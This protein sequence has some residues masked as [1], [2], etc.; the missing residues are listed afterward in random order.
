MRHTPEYARAHYW[1]RRNYGMMPIC[2]ADNCKNKSKKF[3]WALKKGKVHGK[4]REN[5]IRLCRSCHMKYDWNEDKQKRL[6]DIGHT[7]EINDKI[8]AYRTGRKF[9]EITKKKM[10]D[11][12]LGVAIPRSWKEVYQFDRDEN[13]VKK[14]DSITAAMKA[15]FSGG[16]IVNVCR[17]KLKT[18]RGYKWEYA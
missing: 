18:Y 10:S 16:G 2:E 4:I 11:T 1:L 12:H 3:D 7:K 6:Y 13:L 15:G 14:W 9:T 8:R 17:G 5:Y